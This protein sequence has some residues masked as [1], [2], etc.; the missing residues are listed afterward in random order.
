MQYIRPGRLAMAGAVVV[1]GIALGLSAPLVLD[2][3]TSELKLAN[4]AVLAATRDGHEIDAPVAIA[5][6]P[7]IRLERGTIALTDAAKA[8]V[9]GGSTGALPKDR[10]AKLVIDGGIFQIAGRGHDGETGPAGAAAHLIE[11]LR[12]LNFQELALRRCIVRAVLPDGRVETLTDVAAEVH[13]NRQSS[14]VIRGSGELRGQSIT[15][16]LSVPATADSKNGARLPLK[17]RMKSPLLDVAFEGR[18]GA[19]EAVQLQGRMELAISNV[20]ETARWVGAPWPQGAGLRDARIKGEFEWQGPALAFDK[21]TFMM[22]GNEATGALA[23]SFAGERPA[24]AGTLAM[25][26]L[27]LTPYVLG[28]S[29]GRIPAFLTWGSAKSESLAAPLGQR[30]DAD[31]RVSASRVLIGDTAFDRFAASLSLKQGRLMADIA[32]IG[33]EGGRGS[34][35]LTAEVAAKEPQISV[36]GR[37]EEIDASRA[38]AVLLGHGALQG[39]STITVDLTAEGD[40]PAELLRALHGKMSFS[41][42]E[43]GRLGIDVRSLVDAAQRGDVEGWGTATRGQT[44]V[45][46]LEAKLRV[47]KGIVASELV[48]ATAGDSLLKAF[49]TV[50]LRSRELDLRLLLDAVP[51]AARP[52][53]SRDVIVFRGPW[54]APSITLER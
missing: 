39:L 36:R 37:L 5:S 2:F 18:L 48:E 16:D 12:S 49:G 8:R 45:D 33:I 47:D 7:R 51:K 20:R 35:Q 24:L 28:K 52:N 15:F 21:A 34:G 41:L 13:V 42:Q 19:A 53:P 30:L 6:A 26:S 43:G 27:D 29:A 23:L 32:E 44:S 54:A 9:T 22:D 1:S 11:A 14:I 17:L 10:S 25:P 46:G 4:A 3:G 50:S 40:T 31:I 38:S